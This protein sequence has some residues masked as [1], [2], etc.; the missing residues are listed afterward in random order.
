MSKVK[1]ITVSLGLTVQPVQYEAIKAASTITLVLDESDD[2][3]AEHTKLC[4]IVRDKVKEAT[5]AAQEAF[6][7]YHSKGDDSSDDDSSWI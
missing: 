7:A 5:F 6:E 3:D 1:E 4:E 2:L